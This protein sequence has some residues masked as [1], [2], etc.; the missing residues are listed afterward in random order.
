MR[1]TKRQIGERQFA[2][3]R[4]PRQRRSQIVFDKIIATAK[5]LFEQEGY[6]HVS[7]NKIAATANL[8]IGSVYQ[9]FT[10]CE[11]IAL[12]VYENS[13]SSAA[14]KMKRRTLDVLS[15]PLEASIPKSIAWIFD[16]FEEDRYVLLQLISEVPELRHAS[17]PLSYDALI[18]H[19]TRMFFAQHFPNIDAAIISRKAY[20]AHSC[21][22]GIIS[23]YLEERPDIL[24][25]DEV[26]AEIAELV[27][28][29]VLT[30]SRPRNTET[31]SYLHKHRESSTS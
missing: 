3:R 14:L 26:I 27:H 15:C 10:S 25:K 20:I 23:R 12:A 2:P 29:Y 24:N 22:V 19:T 8:S 1:M 7:T 31:P 21:I 9:Y 6:A 4:F 11:S 5:N 13:C 16:M 17:Q 30:L 28:P 18:Q